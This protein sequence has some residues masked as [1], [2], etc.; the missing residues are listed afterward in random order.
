VS[1]ALA[2]APMLHAQGQLAAPAKKSAASATTS[3]T[4]SVDNILNHY[5]EAV[6]GRAAWQKLKSRVSMGTIRVTSANLNG[7]VVIHE[8]APD[9]IL[10]IIVVAGSAFRQGFDGT[11]GWAEDL[12]SGVREQ[13]GAELSESKRQADFYSPLDVK[14]HYAKLTLTGSERVN[15]HDAYVIEAT[16]PEGGPADR[17][18]FDTQTGLPVRLVSVHDSPEGD[19]QFQEDFGDYRKVDDV[20]LPFEITQTG[21]DSAFVVKLDQV[22]HNV[23]IEDSEFAK[24][25]VQ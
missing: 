9:K 24:P 22:H 1:F 11:K 25:A 2:A 17:L 5:V 15:E 14:Q 8:K 19:A 16:L 10:T 12:Q 20:L 7:T 13:S 18:Y 4:P 21:G 3:G 6:G 23:Q